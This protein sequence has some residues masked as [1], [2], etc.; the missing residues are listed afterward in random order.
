MGSRLKVE[1]VE[2]SQPITPGT[3]RLGST[4]RPTAKRTIQI[5]SS[6]GIPAFKRQGSVRRRYSDFVTFRKMLEEES[7]RVIIPPLPGK[8]LLTSNK[9]N[10]LNIEN[11]RQG[12][13]KFLTIVSG[14]PLL[15]TG[16]STLV[17]FIQNE[18]WTPK[19]V[20]Y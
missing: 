17:D 1:Y 6:T 16:S 18:K 20:Y 15:Q 19:H 10:D 7:T 2:N 11:R 8:I 4:L 12:L 3:N 9:F 14:H 5:E 13:E